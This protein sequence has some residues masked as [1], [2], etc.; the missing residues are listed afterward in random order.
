MNNRIKEIKTK[1]EEL[2]TIRE[3]LK[4]FGSDKHQFKLNDCKNEI[5]LKEFE[6]KNSVLLPHDYREFLKT[7]GNGG[8]GPNYG[9]EPIENGININLDIPN[10]ISELDKPFPFTKEW[11]IEPVKT[12]DD[13]YFLKRENE[14]YKAKWLNGSLKIS[15]MG[16][17]IWVNLVIK[18]EEYGNLWIDHRSSDQ[19]IRPLKT[20]TLSRL[21][22]MDWYELWLDESL[23]PL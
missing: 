16:C 7:I 6:S 3:N 10:D 11:N 14:Y 2:I 4:L 20:K 1:V 12:V 17:G 15:N 8:V 21:Q 18:G 13:P 19:G 23:K 22:F 9:L 5:E